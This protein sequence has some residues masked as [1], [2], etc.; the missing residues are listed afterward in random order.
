MPWNTNYVDLFV[1][2]FSLC[3]SNP[4]RACNASICNIG[5]TQSI[6]AANPRSKPITRPTYMKSSGNDNIYLNGGE[7][8]EVALILDGCCCCDCKSNSFCLFLKT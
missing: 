7:E 8:E 3:F 2:A 5:Q 1:N 4:T 6:S